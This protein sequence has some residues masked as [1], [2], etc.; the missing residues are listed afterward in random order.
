MPNNIIGADGITRDARSRYRQRAEGGAH[1]AFE[2]E[3]K[4]AGGAPRAEVEV[5]R[6]A[7]PGDVAAILGKE[8]GEEVVIRQRRMYAGEHLVQLAVTYIPEF[9]AAA[10]PAVAQLDTGQGGIISRMADAGLAQTDVVE[11]VTQVPATADQAAALGVEEGEPLLAITHIGRTEAG[12][13]VEVTRHVLGRGW[14]LRY[15]VPL[16]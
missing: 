8:A 9:V 15:G 14:T 1:G 16:D 10:A 6:G 5:L 12:Q 11:D 13:I 4:R 2:A 7:A 3:V